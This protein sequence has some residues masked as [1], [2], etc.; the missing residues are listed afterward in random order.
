MPRISAGVLLCAGSHTFAFLRGHRAARVSSAISF[1]PCPLTFCDS[2]LLPYSN[3]PLLSAGLLNSAIVWFHLYYTQE[4]EKCSNVPLTY[5]N[6]R[7]IIVSHEETIQA[8][9]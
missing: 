1:R 5:P 8:R 9:R 2:S 3:L 6:V 7:F 4:K